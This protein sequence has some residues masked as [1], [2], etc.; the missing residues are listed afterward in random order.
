MSFLS[1]FSS[2]LRFGF[3]NAVQKWY[4][5]WKIIFLLFSRLRLDEFLALVEQSE[6]DEVGNIDIF[7]LQ[8]LMDYCTILDQ[9]SY[10]Q[11]Q[12]FNVLTPSW[13]VTMILKV[14]LSYYKSRKRAKKTSVPQRMKWKENT[15]AGMV[16]DCVPLYMR[17]E[18]DAAKSYQTATPFKQFFL[19]MNWWTIPKTKQIYTLSKKQT[20]CLWT[21]LAVWICGD[22]Y[23][24]KRMFWSREDYTPN[25]Y[26]HNAFG[27]IVLKKYWDPFIWMITTCWIRPIISISFVRWERCW[28][29]RLKSMA[30]WKRICASM[31]AWFRTMESLRQA[32]HKKKTNYRFGFKNWALCHSTGYLLSFEIYIG[33]S[34]WT[35]KHFGVGGDIVLSLMTDCNIQPNQILVVFWKDNRVGTIASTY[36][37]PNIKTCSRWPKEKREK[38]LSFANYNKGM[39]GIY[40]IDQLDISRHK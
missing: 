4:F 7:A 35:E 15:T 9:S 39:G 38:K 8:P 34:E 28:T 30:E 3:Q 21:E 26:W 32:V 18:S 16:V 5:S 20:F 1:N 24:N 13:T 25:I 22:M 17:V 40:K 12:H 19:P 23:L 11:G 27:C 10:K 2:H 31:R 36:D 37:C 29:K 14:P 33:K 6:E